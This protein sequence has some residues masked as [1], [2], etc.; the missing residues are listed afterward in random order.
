[1]IIGNGLLATA[2]KRHDIPNGNIIYL[3]AGVSDSAEKSPAEFLREEK[4]I[5]D[6]LSKNTRIVY[7]SSCS[8]LDP[9]KTDNP[10]V[11]HKLAMEKLLG[12]RSDTL[13]LRLAQ[14]VGK[15]SNLKLLTNFLFNKISREESFSVW[16]QARRNLI[17]VEH[18]VKIAD[19]F[20]GTITSP[21]KPINIAS[22]D[23]VSSLELVR[24]FEDVLGKKSKYALVDSGGNYDIDVEQCLLAA[25]C[26]NLD[27]KSSYA[28]RCIQK[29]YGQ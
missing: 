13:I 28:K 12:Q 26:L 15:S 25:S 20:C 5:R 24:I 23:P 22:A 21:T 29:Y 11:V 2:L 6:C 19:H 27:L 14:V 3:A 9:T 18:V 4:L 7:F 17:D 1:M 10:Y 16:S 8:V